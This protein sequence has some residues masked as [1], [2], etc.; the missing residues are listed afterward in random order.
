MTILAAL[1]LSA[2]PAPAVDPACAIAEPWTSWSQSGQAKAGAQV[3]GAPVLILGKPVTAT[4]TPADYVQFASAPGKGAKVGYGGL[5]TLSVKVAGR[6]G[7]GLDGPAWVDVVTGTKAQASVEHGHGEPCSGIR[8]IV[9]FDL[10]AGRHVV[11]IAG[12]K[13]EAIRVMV[14]DKLANQPVR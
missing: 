1:L 10:P 6:I 8:K 7:I 3:L 14:A 12:S 5:F 2:A 4:L 9:W 13:A 11:Q